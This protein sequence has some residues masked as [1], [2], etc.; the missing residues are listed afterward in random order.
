MDKVLIA[1]SLLSLTTPSV[2]AQV[3]PDERP[4]LK[5]Q[6]AGPN[7]P[8]VEDPQT[9]A[10]KAFA[11]DSKLKYDSSGKSGKGISTTNELGIPDICNMKPLPPQCRRNQSEYR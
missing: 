10:A 5:P 11:E 4:R 6:I 1:I 8:K 3:T 2:L 9:S 7:K